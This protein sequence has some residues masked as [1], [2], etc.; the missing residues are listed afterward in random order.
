MNATW[1]GAKKKAGV[2]TVN[3]CHRIQNIDLHDEDLQTQYGFTT[4]HHD[5]PIYCAQCKGV[6]V[7]DYS[8]DPASANWVATKRI[9]M[10]PV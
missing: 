4:D 2:Q 6:T 8:V 3:I 9:R 10:T 1:A 7:R 5:C